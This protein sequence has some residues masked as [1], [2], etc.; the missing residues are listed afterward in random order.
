MFYAEFIFDESYTAAAFAQ[1]DAPWEG[2]NEGR[3]ESPRSTSHML[4]PS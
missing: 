2:G 3:G 1:E 4:F